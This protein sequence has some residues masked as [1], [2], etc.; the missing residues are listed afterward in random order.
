MASNGR[1]GSTPAPSTEREVQNGLLF[2]CIGGGLCV[3][4][5]HG[6]MP[7]TANVIG[8]NTC[9]LG[10]WP[11]LLRPLRPIR[12]MRPLGRSLAATHP[13][14]PS[15]RGATATNQLLLATLPRH[16]FCH[17]ERSAAQSKYLSIIGYSWVRFAFWVLWVRPAAFMGSMGYV[18]YMGYVAIQKI[19]T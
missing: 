17:I 15:R 19:P 1:A 10:K 8:I 9:K 13:L 5:W 12:P 3:V 11:F 14:L 18:S 7:P 4:S 2:F 16:I 6:A